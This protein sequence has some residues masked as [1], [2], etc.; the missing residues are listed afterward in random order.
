MSGGGNMTPGEEPHLRQILTAMQQSLTQKYTKIDSLSFRMDKLMERLEKH[1]ERLDQSERC[2]SEVKDGQAIKSS[3]HAKMVKELAVLQAK[4]EDLEARSHRNNLRI[5]G[6]AEYIAIDNMESY[7]ERLLVQ[8]L[9]RE[10]FSSVFVVERAH[11]VLMARP[12]PAAPPCPIIA[13]L[14]NYRDHDTTLR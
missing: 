9:G 14:F 6:I 5:V 13:K 12:P 2:I 3:R 1:A 8:L 10:T 7:V 4:V 11:R